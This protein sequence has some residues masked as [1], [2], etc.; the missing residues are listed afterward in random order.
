MS[1]L[2]GDRP[3]KGG[4]ITSGLRRD[5]VCGMAIEPGAATVSAEHRGQ[6]YR[7]CSDACRARSAADPERYTPAY[8]P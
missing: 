7:F 2:A 5:P 8:R 6:S 4:G 1:D 3:L